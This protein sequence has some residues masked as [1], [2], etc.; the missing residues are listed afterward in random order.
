M[1]PIDNSKTR[2]QGK[3]EVF[4]RALEEFFHLWP[5]RR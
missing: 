5:A 2:K 1:P 3:V 4:A